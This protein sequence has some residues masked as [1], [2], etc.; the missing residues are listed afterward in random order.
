MEALQYRSTVWNCRQLCQDTTIPQETC[1]AVPL[2]VFIMKTNPTSGRYAEYITWL[3]TYFPLQGQTVFRYL[4]THYPAWKY[5]FTYLLVQWML[6]HVAKTLSLL[7]QPLRTRVLGG[8]AKF[9]KAHGLSNPKA[10]KTVGRSSQLHLTQTKTAKISY[11][12]CDGLFHWS[13]VG[14]GPYGRSEI[15]QM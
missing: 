9:A 14:D 10:K 13:A 4:K 7:C 3:R 2:F 8:V 5:S 1:H 11:Y 6:Y 15:S 12:T